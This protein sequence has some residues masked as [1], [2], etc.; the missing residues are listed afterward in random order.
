[1]R[2]KNLGLLLFLAIFKTVNKMLNIM[3]NREKLVEY[4]KNIIFVIFKDDNSRL[5]Y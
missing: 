4:A 1:M 3:I 2:Y 5:C